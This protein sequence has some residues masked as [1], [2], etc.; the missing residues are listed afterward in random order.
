MTAYPDGHLY[1]T[2]SAGILVSIQN[3]KGVVR[4]K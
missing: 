1:S 4:V 2:V 3:E